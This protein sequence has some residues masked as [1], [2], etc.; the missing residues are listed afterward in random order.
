MVLCA[1]E[2]IEGDRSEPI[3]AGAADVGHVER[4]VFR[5]GRRLVGIDSSVGRRHVTG[6]AVF[7][8]GRQAAPMAGRTGRGPRHS[9]DTIE[10]RAVAAVA[11]VKAGGT[12][13]AVEIPRGAKRIES[14][15]RAE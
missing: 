7:Q 10:V 4:A 15:Y 14:C 6:G 11:G 13:F 2:M 12:G 1:E 8:R 5:M 3:V 9:P